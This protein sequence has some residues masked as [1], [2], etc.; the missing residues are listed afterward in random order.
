MT[1]PYLWG[2]YLHSCSAARTVHVPG[3]EELRNYCAP[4]EHTLFSRC[5]VYRKAFSRSE[6][7]HVDRFPAGPDLVFSGPTGRR[8]N[9]THSPVLTAKR[10]ER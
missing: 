5:P 8:P 1:C 7:G 3:M 9:A 10:N 4:R 2:I 6:S